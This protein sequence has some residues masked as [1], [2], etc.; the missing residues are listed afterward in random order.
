MSDIDALCEAC[1][2]GD[3]ETVEDILNREG[4]DI[5]ATDGFGDTALM[6]AMMYDQC[7]IVRALLTR[8]GLSLAKTNSA[9]STALHYAC[10]YNRSS[11]IRIFC[12]DRRASARIV[13]KKNKAGDTALMSGVRWGCLDSVKELDMVE[14][15]DFHTEN[16]EGRNLV[17]EARMFQKYL[18]LKYLIK[19]KVDSLKVIAAHRVAQYVQKE[20]DV[21]ELEIPTSLHGLVVGFMDS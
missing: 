20:S 4:V 11:V 13:N 18:V 21:E 16:R 15:I 8:P 7:N 1:C 14:G 2:D 5:N 10:R 3:V 9:G 17:E 12:Q 19:R 6:C